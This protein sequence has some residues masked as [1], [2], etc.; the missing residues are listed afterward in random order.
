MI[1]YCDTSFLVSFLYEGDANHKAARDL[2]GRFDGQDF[3]L[4]A[5]SPIGVARF[6]SRGHAPDGIAH[7]YPRGPHRY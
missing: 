5:D 1:V 7:S 3:V 6:R 2:A 4:C